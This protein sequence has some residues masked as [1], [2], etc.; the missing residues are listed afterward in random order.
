VVQPKKTCESLTPKR[1]SQITKE[2][3]ASKRRT[4]FCDRNGALN[5]NEAYT[6]AWRAERDIREQITFREK[7]SKGGE[8]QGRSTPTRRKPIFG[9][10]LLPEDRREE[11]HAQQNRIQKGCQTRPRGRTRPSCNDPILELEEQRNVRRKERI[12]FSKFYLR[13]SQGREEKAGKLNPAELSF[14]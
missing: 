7:T 6:I 14:C 10:V 1:I 2:E 13:K 8:N 12:Q 4:N 5:T 11:K 9:L 3:S